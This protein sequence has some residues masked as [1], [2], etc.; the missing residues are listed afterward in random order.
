MSIIM[1][2]NYSVCFN[3]HFTCM[4]IGVSVGSTEIDINS[5][6]K[7]NTASGC[8]KQMPSHCLSNPCPDYSTCQE[9]F[10][11]YMCLCPAGYVGKH[12]VDVCS[13][14]PCRHGRCEKTDTAKG[15]Q[16]VCPKQ[17]T[18]KIIFHNSL[19]HTILR[20]LYIEVLQLSR[21]HPWDIKKCLFRRGV[22]LSASYVSRAK[23]LLMEGVH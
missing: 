21:E 5:G 14:R 22:A 2:E 23:C 20:G 10:D 7:H 12:C 11:S 16:C 18:G 1:K 8:E 4:S 6:D 9:E 15:F 3:F 19:I 17:Y 13:L